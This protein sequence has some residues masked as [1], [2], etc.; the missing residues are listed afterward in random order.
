MRRI[1]TTLKDQ[2]LWTRAKSASITE[3]T[4]FHWET[5][6]KE[7]YGEIAEIFEAMLDGMKNTLNKMVAL[8]IKEIVDEFGLDPAE[9]NSAMPQVDLVE[10]SI[11]EYAA[12]LIE[13]VITLPTLPALEI[14]D[15]LEQWLH[16]LVEYHT[17]E[18]N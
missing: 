4:E 2:I 16:D 14:V 9:K 13:D 8:E 1:S 10:E 18:R 15:E 6:T 17:S 7:Q 5:Y 12:E 11:V 3:Q